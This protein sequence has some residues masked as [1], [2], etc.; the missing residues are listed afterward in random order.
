MRALVYGWGSDLMEALPPLLTRAGFSV[1]V[2][3][4]DKNF[5]KSKQANHVLIVGSIK[6]LIEELARGS[7]TD[8]QLYVPTDD[9]TLAEINGSNIPVDKKTYLL[10]V[11]NKENLSHIYSKIGLAKILEQS[12]ICSPKYSI[13]LNK[14]DIFESVKTIPFPFV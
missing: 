10:P 7:S 3:T 5:N 14:S 9:Q 13:A 11:I 6:D 8:Y 4:L 1:D 2:I 12:Q